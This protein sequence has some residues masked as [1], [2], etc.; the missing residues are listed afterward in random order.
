[1]TGI[2]VTWSTIFLIASVSF[3]SFGRCSFVRPCTARAETPVVSII[4]TRSSVAWINTILQN[5]TYLSQRE[6][7]SALVGESKIALPVWK[8]SNFAGHWNSLADRSH[9]L[10][11]DVP[12][13]KNFV[14]TFCTWI[15]K[16]WSTRLLISTLLTFSGCVSNA[17]PIPPFKLKPLGQPMFTSI[18]VS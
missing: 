15:L 11:K 6:N 2:F 14:R 12:H 4:E 5:F 1:M 3:G 13:L 17:A 8:K 18:P 16:I 9:K 10:C 7:D